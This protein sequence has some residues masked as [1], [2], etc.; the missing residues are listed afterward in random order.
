[1]DKFS[2]DA[3]DAFAELRRR[4]WTQQ[5]IADE[6]KVNQATVSRKLA[7]VELYALGHNRPKFWVAYQ[8]VKTPRSNPEELTPPEPSTKIT[9]AQLI[10]S[11]MSNEWYTPAK[12]IAAARQVL[13]GIDLDP[14]SCEAANK[15]V[16]AGKFYTIDNNGLQFPWEGRVW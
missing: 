16:Q 1:A 14:A 5:E 4:G 6:C 3:A 2:W 12:Y 15:T 8:E 7:C 9:P 11:S 10:V 13:G